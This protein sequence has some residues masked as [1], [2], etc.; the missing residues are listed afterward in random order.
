MNEQVAR[1]VVLVRSIESMDGKHEV[2]SDD[3]R[4]YAS[5][6]AKELAQWQASDSKSAVTTE[7]FLQQR[8]EQILKRLGERTPA[9]AAIARRRGGFKALSLGVPLLALVLGA[10][11]DRIGDPHRV[12]LLS[13]PLLAII[14]WN[15]L[16]YL[17][18]MA[19]VL[20]PARK[21]GWVSPAL[22]RRLSG[23]Q[24][25]LPRKLPNVLAAGL[26]NFS[27]QWS[28][29]SAKLTQARLARTMHLAA[30]MFAVGAV[31]S[32]YARGFLTQ[33]VAGWESTFLN[34]TQVHGVLSVLFAPAVALLPLEGFSI[35][36]IEALQ[37]SKVPTGAGGAKWVHLYGASLLL[38]VVLPRLVLAGVAHWRAQ[39]MRNTF[40][41]DL[42]Q[43][44]FRKLNGEAGTS[45]PALLRVL[46]YSYTLDEARDKGLAQIAVTLFGEQA[47]VMLRPSSGYGEEAV[48]T[49]RDLS[50]EDANVT[51]TA[52]L[53]SLAATPEKENHGAFLD[54]L[55]RASQRGIAVLID[56]S[57]L[58]ERSGAQAGAD[59]RLAERTALWQ[60]FC[61]FHRAPATIV[62]LLHPER[63]PLELGAGL[64][65]S[66]AS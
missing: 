51:A 48:D 7:H 13:A 54:H 15:M 43:P 21:N 17:L 3:D 39:R 50:V 40:P 28:E 14:G 61:Q 9:F 60:Q 27:L 1:D 55:V 25:S 24:L 65:L 37:F 45:A 38:L 30:A 26:T 64:S 22:M 33:Y 2:L 62:N 42:E 63:R 36:D 53:F 4:L 41:L 59:V 49:L 44:Y 56:E 46:P 16:V 57:A 10:A 12:D 11:V 58:T 8:A 31:L 20:V 32:L 47:R 29:L 6:S 35:A 19:W 5:R 52:V 66:K 34:A 23:A 18:L